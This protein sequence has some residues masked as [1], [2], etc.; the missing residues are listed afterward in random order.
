MK[1]K[2]FLDLDKEA[3][4]C[5]LRATR[6]TL[7]AKTLANQRDYFDFGVWYQANRYA[8]GPGAPA[9]LEENVLIAV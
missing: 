5:L 6:Q 2:S 7:Y 9:T 3:D 8:R 1:G 4:T